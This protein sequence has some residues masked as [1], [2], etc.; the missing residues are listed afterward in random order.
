MRKCLIMLVILMMAV[1][2]SAQDTI[3]LQPVEVSAPA[4]KTDVAE[5]TMERSVDTSVMKRLN[6][7]SMSQLLI[8]HSP[9][10]IKTYG[11]GGTATASFRGTTASHTLVLWNGFQLNAPSLGQVDFSTIPVFMTDQ[12]SLKWGAGTS[13][14][15]GGLGGVVN[16]NNDEYFCKGLIVNVKQT[17]GSFNTL[18]SFATVGYSWANHLLRVKAFRTSS[19]NDFTYINIGV[20]PHQKMKQKNA[21][22]VDYGMM[23]EYQWRFGNSLISIVSWNQK[24]HRNCPQIMPNVNNDNTVEYTDN[25]FSRNYVSFKNYWNTGKIEVKSAYFRENQRYVLNTFTDIGTLVTSMDSKNTANVFHQIADVEQRLYKNWKLNAKI[26][27]DHEQVES[28]DYEG[29]KKRDVFSTYAALN[30]NVLKNIDLRATLR[31][32]IVDGKSVGFFPTATASYSCIY[33]KGLKISAGYSH[34]YRNPSLNDLYWNPGGNPDLKPEDGRTADGNLNYIRDFGRFS[35][36]SQV[37]A[38]YSKVSDWIQWKPT[39]YRYWVP[40]NVSTVVAYGADVHLKMNYNIEN[41]KFSVSGNY[42]YAHTTDENDKQLIY[43]PLHH[44]NAFADIEWKGWNISYTV[45]FTGE[46][47]TSMNDNEFYGF[48]LMPYALHHISL[49]KHVLKLDIELKINNLTDEDYQAI[50]WRAM[51]GRSYEVAINF[52]L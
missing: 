37:S 12:I 16:I 20:I 19:D 42:V 13:A 5:T 17:Y 45:E 8:Q 31:N 21:D 2:V 30:G 33:L 3:V 25:D 34:N 36:E 28:S 48:R 32:D 24:S 41:W 26:Q 14:N 47:K 52:K 49:G 43:I 50:L 1:V 29:V 38:Y 35:V 51:P 23:P 6:S 18:G 27:W 39:S 46:R 22:Y 40:E 11:P 10:F 9:V 15:S 7:V 4:I 44:A